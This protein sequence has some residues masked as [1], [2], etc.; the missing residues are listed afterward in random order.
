MCPRPSLNFLFAVFLVAAL[1]AA[2]DMPGAQGARGPAAVTV[3]EVQTRTVTL[4]TKLPGRVAASAQAEVRPQVN[5]IIEERLFEEGAQVEQGQ[6]LYQIDTDTYDA[7]VASAKAAVTQAEAQLR[8]AETE[9]KRLLELQD[10]D[11]ASQ[12]AVDDAVAARE[13]AAAALQVARARLRSAEIE[14]ERTTVRARLTGEIGLSRTSPGALVT[15]SQSNPLA[16]IR[17]LDPVY[18]DVTQS[19]AELLE[20]QRR[21]AS[22][23]EDV[24]QREVE[25]I[26]ADGQRYSETGVL[27]AAEPNV[28]PLTGVVTLRME[29][30]NPDRLLLPGMYVQVV[31]PTVTQE[32]AVLVPQQAVTRDRRGR[33]VAWVVGQ[34]NVVEERALTILQDLGADWVVSEGLSGG[35]RLVLE[36]FQKTQPGAE[37]A[38]Q[39]RDPA[40]QAKD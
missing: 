12:Q 39:P 8:A 40:E 4:T 7:Q 1:C 27:T 21:Q 24:P 30:A 15:A 9:A 18:V 23:P 10:R 26:L 31:L 11:V 20:W 16:I 38:P 6:A 22:G 5:G 14:L 3:T 2:P 32:N 37:V 33:P 28:D 36:G 13:T 29:F 34:D 25:L 19:A 35:E 17:A